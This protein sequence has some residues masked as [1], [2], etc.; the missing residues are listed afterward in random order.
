MQLGEALADRFL[1]GAVRLGHGRQIRLGVDHEILGQEPIHRDDI[2][3]V[4]QGEREI[5]VGGHV[6][7]WY[8]PD[9]LPITL[10]HQ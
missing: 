10:T 4:R 5:E 3:D 7:A 2:R 9:P 1:D 8:S 6:A